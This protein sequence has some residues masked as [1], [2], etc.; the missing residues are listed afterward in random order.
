MDDDEYGFEKRFKSYDVEELI[1]TFNADVGN[2]G[3]VRARGVFHNPLRKAFLATGLDCSSFITDRGISL[4]HIM[5][6]GDRIVP[7]EMSEV[8]SG[9]RDDLQ[10]QGWSVDVMVCWAISQTMEVLGLDVHESMDFLSRNKKL[11]FVDQTVTTQ[12]SFQ[13]L[14]KEAQAVNKILE[15][16]AYS[17]ENE[18][19][20]ISEDP[21]RGRK[22]RNVR[23]V[24]KGI[25]WVLT[26][27]VVVAGI[28][29]VNTR[30][31]WC[32]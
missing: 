32:N 14:L 18:P 12:L 27:F 15:L 3:W 19:E 1:T 17:V 8:V 28:T 24:I 2:P 31:R 16:P 26:Y 4:C 29:Y 5:R 22:E 21:K 6:S 30:K 11:F 25:A 20:F 13:T 7:W 9:W 23:M 10:A